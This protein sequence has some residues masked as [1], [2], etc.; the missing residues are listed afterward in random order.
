M[1]RQGAGNGVLNLQLYSWT[2][3]TSPDAEMANSMPGAAPDATT[4]RE[5][6][7]LAIHSGCGCHYR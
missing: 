6:R 3:S 7:H 5:R 2:T 4:D 1:C